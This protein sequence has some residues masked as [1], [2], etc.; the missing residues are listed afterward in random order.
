MDKIKLS[1]RLPRTAQARAFYPEHIQ[2]IIRKDQWSPEDIELVLASL[3]LQD[4]LDQFLFLLKERPSHR[5]WHVLILMKPLPSDLRYL[6]PMY[7]HVKESRD[8]H[9]LTRYTC[10][11]MHLKEYDYVEIF[12]NESWFWRCAIQNRDLE[13]IKT[14]T[15]DANNFVNIVMMTNSPITM[16]PR[17]MSSGLNVHLSP[18][19]LCKLVYQNMDLRIF[20]HIVE[21]LSPEIIRM[22]YPLAGSVP[23]DYFSIIYNHCPMPTEAKWFSAENRVYSSAK[24][25]VVDSQLNLQWDFYLWGFALLLEEGYFS[26]KDAALLR[27]MAFFESVRCLELK[28]RL[29]KATFRQEGYFTSRQTAV[30]LQMCLR[31]LRK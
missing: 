14:L 7:R 13:Y 3:Y 12:K 28:E 11:M 8:N 24:G 18:S 25:G 10:I 2:E 9:V 29:V 16:F 31:L 5:L 20:C 17:D 26:T 22:Y 1:L 4:H 27:F 15:V 6:K 30:A 21:S 19:F 23:R